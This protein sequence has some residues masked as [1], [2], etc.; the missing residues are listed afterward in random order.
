MYQKKLERLVIAAML[1]AMVFAATWISIPAPVVGNVNL[2]DAMILLSAWIL[3]GP[4]AVAA[5]A[6][7]ATLTDL[8]GAYAAYAPGTLVIKA[9]MTV[10]A[11][12]LLKIC[13]K[14]RL[15]MLP[16]LL[17]SGAC[18]EAIMI[19]GYYL[20]EAVFF[21]LGFGAAA[22]NIPFNAMQGAISLTLA[23]LC[24]LLLKKTGFRLP[25]DSDQI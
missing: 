20:Y 23:V 4:W 9:L 22:L 3:G 8:M 10:S 15:P 19:L 7:G 1:C 24:R 17:I 6:A 14:A 18:A 2:G 25:V 11:I 12:L 5:A 16:S 21:S 13:R